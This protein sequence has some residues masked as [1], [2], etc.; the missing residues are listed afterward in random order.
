MRR[1]A[2]RAACCAVAVAGCA[3]VFPAKYALQ[4]ALKLEAEG[5][6]AEAVAKYE[7]IAR[8]HRDKPEAETALS[9]AAEIYEERMRNWQK[10]AILLQEL[11]GLTEGT[12]RSA[13][14]LLRLA[15][16]LEQSGSPYTDALAMYGVIC[17]DCATEP[18]SV[19]A[20]LAQGRIYESMRRWTEAKQSYEEAISRHGT[21]CG[22]GT[23]LT[24]LQSIWLLE[25]M[26]AYQEGRLDE[27]V[28]MARTA[29]GREIVAPE[30]RQGLQNLLRRYEVAETLWNSW[31][32]EIFVTGAAIAD[33]DDPAGYACLAER[34]KSHQPP[35]GWEIEFSDKAGTFRLREAPGSSTASSG[36]QK[37]AVKKWSY[38]SPAG[39]RV[40]AAWWSLDG[41]YLVWSARSG[42]KGSRFR[43]IRMLDVVARKDWRVTKDDTGKLLGETVLYLPRSRKLVFPYGSYLVIS[44]LRGGNRVQLEVRSS[45]KIGA[46]FR[47][48]EVV[49]LASSGD[50]LDLAMA[51]KQPSRGKDAPPVVRYWR[52][53][54]SARKGRI[55]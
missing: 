11:R 31:P 35:E 21:A 7:A 3:Y 44:D 24:R 25:A 45:S 20:L 43:E 8:D 38:G 18:E 29:L 19:S 51:V 53:N 52:F 10:A 40:G 36:A 39:M 13:E 46:V 5:L 12:P 15:R 16:I 32:D 37:P 4:E 9:R 50:G 34:G 27:G 23:V 1:S 14:V 47:M 22:A 6:Y 41:K 48:D 26:G 2:L 42:R 28:A 33:E 54:L 30:V 17:K 55:G 49:W